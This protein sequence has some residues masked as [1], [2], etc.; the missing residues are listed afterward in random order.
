MSEPFSR[1]GS[2]KVRTVHTA[3]SGTDE[4]LLGEKP[5]KLLP[6]YYGNTQVDYM[7]GWS[8]CIINM[9]RITAFGL[10]TRESMLRISSEYAS[11]PCPN[12]LES[13]PK[14]LLLTTVNYP[15]N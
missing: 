1:I 6:T 2:D 14:G 5:G 7:V 3:G 10:A 13:A 8:R 11:W 9:L 15:I 12:T 4:K